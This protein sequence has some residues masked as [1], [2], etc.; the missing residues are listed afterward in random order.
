MRQLYGI[1]NLIK[2]SISYTEGEIKTISVSN[3]F[4]ENIFLTDRYVERRFGGQ[5][6]G[7]FQIGKAKIRSWFSNILR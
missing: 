3:N 7:I 4:V 6:M 2:K 5:E 1:L